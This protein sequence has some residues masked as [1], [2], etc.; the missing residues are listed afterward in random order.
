MTHLAVETLNREEIILDGI[1]YYS[2]IKDPTKSLRN[3]SKEEYL[4]I[5]EEYTN[6]MYGYFVEGA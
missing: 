6:L 1:G 5:K 3:M 2:T 4:A